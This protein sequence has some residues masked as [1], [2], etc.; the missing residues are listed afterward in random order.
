M[1][2]R[3]LPLLFEVDDEREGDD[4]EDENDDQLPGLVLDDITVSDMTVGVTD[5]RSTTSRSVA[6]V[7]QLM[8]NEACD[9]AILPWGTTWDD[10]DQ[11]CGVFQHKNTWVL[12]TIKLP[13][14][15]GANTR[16]W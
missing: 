1:A 8:S 15:G 6:K 5:A 13:K 4:I 7:A 3:T 16:N 11:L 9:T 14:Q 10:V 12:I 2:T